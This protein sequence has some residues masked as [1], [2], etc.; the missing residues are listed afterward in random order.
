MNIYTVKTHKQAAIDFLNLGIAGKIR[1]A[2]ERYISK[3]FIHHN[4]NFEGDRE[5]LLIA[6]E[7]SHAMYPSKVMVIKNVLQDGD[8]VAVHSHVRMQP[9]YSPGIA[10]VHI[11]RFKGR[12]VVELWDLNQP[13]PEQTPNKH[14]MF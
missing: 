6:M 5:S 8:L 10:L 12:K 14:G 7:E 2:Y 3:D 13:V 11:F 4:I 9:D 1:E